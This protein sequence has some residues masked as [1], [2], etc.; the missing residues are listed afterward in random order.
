VQNIRLLF[1]YTLFMEIAGYQRQ[2]DLSR[3][4]PTMVIASALI[5]AIRTAKWPRIHTETASRIEWDL[6]VEQAVRMAHSVLSHLLAKSPCLFQHKDV[7]WY[8]PSEDE[9]PK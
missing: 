5:L 4:G 1:A 9:S 8:Q 3:L 7:P 6:E 2:V